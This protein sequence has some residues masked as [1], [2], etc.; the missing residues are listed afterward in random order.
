MDVSTHPVSVWYCDLGPD[1]AA[2]LAAS[3]RFLART[4]VAGLCPHLHNP[5]MCPACPEITKQTLLN[6]K[7]G[8]VTFRD[9]RLV[10]F[11]NQ[12][13]KHRFTIAIANELLIVFVMPS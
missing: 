1:A 7:G 3:H 13:K 5:K 6:L 11:Q 4:P 2:A 9:C 12:I 8:C 10:L